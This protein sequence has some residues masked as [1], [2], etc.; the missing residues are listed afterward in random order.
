MNNGIKTNRTKSFIAGDQ[1]QVHYHNHMKTPHMHSINCERYVSGLDEN[2]KQRFYFT[3][4]LTPVRVYLSYDV[5]KENEK[6]EIHY[7]ALNGRKLSPKSLRKNFKLKDSLIN[8]AKNLVFHS[9]CKSF[10]PPQA[11]PDRFNRRSYSASQT[12]LA[13]R[14]NYKYISSDLNVLKNPNVESTKLDKKLNP[15]AP[16][17]LDNEKVIQ[18]KIPETAIN[19]GQKVSSVQNNQK[20]EVS[21]TKVRRSQKSKRIRVD[22]IELKINSSNNHYSNEKL[23]PISSFNRSYSY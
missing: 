6:Q 13:Q 8:V 22:S 1:R 5:S 21:I 10:I 23:N 9:Y 12:S 16:K 15:E 11:H 2:R 18:K 7:N 14:D 4:N 3:S 20:P 19:F 17:K